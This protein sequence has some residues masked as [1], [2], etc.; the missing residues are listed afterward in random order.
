MITLIP[1]DRHF[2]TA[3]GTAA[4]GGSIM[5]MR[6]TN[7]RASVGKLISSASKLNPFGYSPASR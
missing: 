2:A 7:V 4:L 3:S 1:A 6:P 5:D